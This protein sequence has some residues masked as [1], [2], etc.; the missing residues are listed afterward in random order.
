[1]KPHALS[2][3]SHVL[4]QIASL[5]CEV[6]LGDC[7]PHRKT[8]II[9]SDPHHDIYRFV[10]GKSSGILSDISSGIRSG[11]VSGISSGILPAH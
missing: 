11:I 2:C 10:A 7:F 3:C 8:N 5:G 4:F 6:R 9:S 1:M